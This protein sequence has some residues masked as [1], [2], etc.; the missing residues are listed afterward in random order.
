VPEL[1]TASAKLIAP[2]DPCGSALI[3]ASV[4][5][6]AAPEGAS[7]NTTTGACA[8]AAAVES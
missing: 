4:S 8:D 6:F 2:T 3:Y 7:W 5:N 1:F